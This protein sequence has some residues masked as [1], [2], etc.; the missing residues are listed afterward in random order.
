MTVYD[1][2]LRWITHGGMLLLIFGA[3]RLIFSRLPILGVVPVLLPLALAA[4]ATLEESR[5]GA[6]FGMV[7]GMLCTVSGSGFWVIP[8][9][10]AA[11]FGL[12]LLT[13]YAL[14]Q[15]LVGHLLGCAALLL[16]RMVWC[17]GTRLLTGAADLPALLRVAVPEFCYSLALAAPVYF[18][19]RFLC[20][21]WGRI[22]YQ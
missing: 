9:C 12:G 3:E 6:A 21:H 16:A 1:R 8:L 15:D 5:F 19:Y 18:I 4:A 10:A 11:G 7:A 13:R 22:Y 17:V 14:R 2:I 20:R